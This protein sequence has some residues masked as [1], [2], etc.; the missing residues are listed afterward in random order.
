[1]QLAKVFAVT[2]AVAAVTLTRFGKE[3][4]NGRSKVSSVFMG[5]FCLGENGL[6]ICYYKVCSECSLICAPLCLEIA[7]SLFFDGDESEQAKFGMILTS[8][9]YQLK[10]VRILGQGIALKIGG[11]FF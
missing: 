10:L 9:K 6:S 5:W 8:L 11:G 2:T 7:F 3:R 1:M 4:S